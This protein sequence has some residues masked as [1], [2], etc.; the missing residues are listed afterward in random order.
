MTMVIHVAGVMTTS[1][2]VM[3]STVRGCII[4]ATGAYTPSAQIV[5]IGME[6]KYANVIEWHKMMDKKLK[7]SLRRATWTT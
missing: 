3:D 2:Q 6:A 1:E 4:M 5:V 7:T